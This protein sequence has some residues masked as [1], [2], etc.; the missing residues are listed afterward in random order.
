MIEVKGQEKKQ[1]NIK[2]I[3]LPRQCNEFYLIVIS[4]LIVYNIFLLFHFHLIPNMEDQFEGQFGFAIHLET[5]YVLDYL[6]CYIFN[7]KPLS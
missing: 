4:L 5:S 1:D 3:K 7:L 6:P 2:V